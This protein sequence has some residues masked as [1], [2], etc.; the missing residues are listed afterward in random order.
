MHAVAGLIVP[1]ITFVIAV[2]GEVSAE[3]ILDTILP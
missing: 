3:R 1:T 2:F